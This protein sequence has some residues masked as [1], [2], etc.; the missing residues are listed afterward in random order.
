MQSNFDVRCLRPHVREPWQ[1]FFGQA[2]G[3]RSN[4]QHYLG[5]KCFP[6]AWTVLCIIHF[7]LNDSSRA[8]GVNA[9][10]NDTFKAVINNKKNELSANLQL[11]SYLHAASLS[12]QQ[13]QQQRRGCVGIKSIRDVPCIRKTSTDKVWQS[14]FNARLLQAEYRSRMYGAHRLME[15]NWSSAEVTVW[16][17]LEAKR[18][19]RRRGLLSRLTIN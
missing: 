13:Q 8:A 15:K 18:S 1:T 4:A 2:D 11:W 9:K 10:Q 5:R 12:E 6:P 7:A 19:A 17:R 16:H 14:I 3:S